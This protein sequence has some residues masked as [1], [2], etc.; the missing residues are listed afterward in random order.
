MNVDSEFLVELLTPFA[1]MTM[2]DDAKPDDYAFEDQKVRVKDVKA[3]R[4]LLKTLVE[5]HVDL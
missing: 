3:V 2:R 4:A 5:S 1:S